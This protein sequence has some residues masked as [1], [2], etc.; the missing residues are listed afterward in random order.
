[1]RIE[2]QYGPAHPGASPRTTCPTRDE[3]VLQALN[4]PAHNGP[5]P[6]VEVITYAP[7]R[8]DTERLNPLEHLL[9][10][11]DEE[12]G[13][14]TSHAKTEPT[15]GDETGGAGIHRHGRSQI[16]SQPAETGDERRDQRGPV[17]RRERKRKR[18]RAMSSSVAMHSMGRA[19]EL[20]LRSPITF[21]INQEGSQTTIAVPEFEIIVQASTEPEAITDAH[22][23]LKD[24]YEEL[25]AQDESSLGDTPLRW[26]RVLDS[27]SY[28]RPAQ[29]TGP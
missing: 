17:D 6:T 16:P 18:S 3:A 8:V 27:L 7:R 23:R 12:Y 28:S 22:D 29:R 26:K 25:T 11:L 14:L 13:D 5:P 9:E 15:P 20:L 10:T 19:G 2:Y 4:A 21:L 24:L 1:M